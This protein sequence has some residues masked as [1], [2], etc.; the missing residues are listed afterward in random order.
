MALDLDRLEQRILGVL[1][2]KEATVPDTYPLT[3]NALVAGCNQK[4]N[5][6][7]QMDVQDYEVEGALRA[8]MDRGWVTRRERDGGR[9][10]RFAHEARTQLGVEKVE[11]ALLC[12]LLCR[13]PQSAAFLSRSTS[14]MARVGS[15]EEVETRLEALATRPVP[16]VQLLPLRARERAQRWCHLLDGRS[17]EEALRGDGQTTAAE[18]QRDRPAAAPPSPSTR[19]STSASSSTMAAAPAA[20]AL[21][22]LEARIE[23]LENAYGDLETRLARLEGR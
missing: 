18:P 23:E 6:E 4:N 22:D 21:Q 15:P 14:R 8:L 13:G 12:D 19:A 11:L 7:P 5:R 1:I 2:E 3:V 16:Y 20:G 10:D 17:R 9:A